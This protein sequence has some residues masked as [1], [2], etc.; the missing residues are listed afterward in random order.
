MVSMSDVPVR[1]RAAE[2]ALEQGASA[3]AVGRVAAEGL[4]PSDSLR[5]SVEYK[6][7]LAR[8]LTARAITE[9]QAV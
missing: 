1:A 7:H 6:L 9:A 5:A 4:S 8:V 3:D 2:S